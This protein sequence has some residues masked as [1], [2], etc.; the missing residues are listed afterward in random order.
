MKYF[1]GNIRINWETMGTG[2]NAGN[3]FPQLGKTGG[4]IPLLQLY[5]IGG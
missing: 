1:K 5:G 4:A 2:G 3:G